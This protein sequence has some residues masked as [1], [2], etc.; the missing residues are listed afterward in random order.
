MVAETW[1]AV[2]NGCIKVDAA[3]MQWIDRKASETYGKPPT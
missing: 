3:L 2:V 1:L